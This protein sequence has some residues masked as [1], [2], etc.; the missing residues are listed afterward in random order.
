RD[1]DFSRDR[2][3]ASEKL[4]VL[5]WDREFEARFL[6]RR[7]SNQL[8]WRWAS[9]SRFPSAFDGE[10]VRLA[11]RP[12]VGHEDRD[13]IAALGSYPSTPLAETPRPSLRCRWA[14]NCLGRRA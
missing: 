11:S 6:Q 4:L 9:W 2:A 13:A 5:R 3:L 7:I 14:R 8:F 1:T 12:R 10:T